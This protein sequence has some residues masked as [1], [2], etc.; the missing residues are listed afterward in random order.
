[1][2]DVT[3]NQAGEGVETPPAGNTNLDSLLEATAAETEAAS[4][5]EG[6]AQ[7][8]DAKVKKQEA[9]AEENKKVALQMAE[10][11]ALEGVNALAKLF[12]KR[13]PHLQID[14]EERQHVA[15]AA[16]PVML[17]H[18][19]G[20]MPA[21]LLPYA[22]EFRL[23]MALAGVGFG[24]YLQAQAHEEAQEKAKQQAE[25]D[26]QNG[27]ARGQQAARADGH[28]GPAPVAPVAATAPAPVAVPAGNHMDGIPAGG[29]L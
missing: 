3:E 24:L 12:N 10:A 6:K 18:A 13:F 27:I 4:A 14:A 26:R 1:M 23:G 22:E 9:Q 21:W 15:S 28:P 19:G 5:T 25:Q 2:G 16:A 7:A 8:T 20:Q 11:G 17:K 29:S